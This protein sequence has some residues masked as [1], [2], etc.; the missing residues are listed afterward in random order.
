MTDREVGGVEWKSDE[1]EDE[2]RPIRYQ[3]MDMSEATDSNAH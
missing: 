2:A 1:D 3:G